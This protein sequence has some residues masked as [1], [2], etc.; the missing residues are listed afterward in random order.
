MESE[1]SI[2]SAVSRCGHSTEKMQSL[3][4]AMQYN[5]MLYFVHYTGHLDQLETMRNLGDV[6]Q[7]SW[8]E[9]VKHSP[10]LEVLQASQ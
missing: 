6:S 7:L 10:G 9:M 8:L 2:D 5:F 3:D 4:I 1:Y